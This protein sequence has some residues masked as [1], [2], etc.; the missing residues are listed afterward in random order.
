[1]VG[2]PNGIIDA[3]SVSFIAGNQA[4][5]A[6]TNLE[7]EEIKRFDS[8]LR[9]LASVYSKSTALGNIWLEDRDTYLWAA[10]IAKSQLNNVEFRGLGANAAGI[11]GM[12]PIRPIYINAT[13]TWIVNRATTGWAASAWNVNMAST[14]AGARNTQNRVVLAA[15]RY[16]NVTTPKTRELRMTVGP[17]TYPVEVLDWSYIG[18]L[19]TAKAIATLFT[20]KNTTFTTDFNIEFTGDD[21]TALWGLAFGLGD[22]MTA[23]T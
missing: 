10:S 9:R 13:Q 2:V 12:Q 3:S 20:P 1:M 8:D 15:P 7:E 11:Y 18:G 14:T 21:G 22:W 16:A 4:N 6:F 5:L 23:E 19:Y 17:T